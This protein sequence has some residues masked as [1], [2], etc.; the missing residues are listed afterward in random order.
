M[1]G[2]SEQ[3]KANKTSMQKLSRWG[4]ELHESGI[5]EAIST[6]YDNN[7]TK[8]ILP[9]KISVYNKQREETD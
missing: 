8:L 5:S 9:S 3:Y 6:S 4:I 7:I 1:T 2:N